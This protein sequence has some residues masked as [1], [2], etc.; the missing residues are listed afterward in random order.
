MLIGKIN[1]CKI[2]D[3]SIKL[4]YKTWDTIFST[5]DI[6]KMFNSFVDSY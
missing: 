3:F 1:E 5:D 6:N 2:N 4:S